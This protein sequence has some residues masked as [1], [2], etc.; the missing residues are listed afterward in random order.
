MRETLTHYNFPAPTPQQVRQTIGLTLEESIHRLTEGRC[1]EPLTSEMVKH[2]RILHTTKAASH[3]PLRRSHP[4][5]RRT[6]SSQHLHHPRKQQRPSRPAPT[7][8]PTRN[9]RL[10]R[11]HPKRRRHTPPQTRRLPLHRPHSAPASP[12]P[13][14]T[15]PRSRRH[16][17]RHSLR[18]ERQPTLLLGSLRLRRRPTLQS[19][20]TRLRTPI[21][22]RPTHAY[23]PLSTELHHLASLF[24][25]F[26][27]R[28]KLCRQFLRLISAASSRSSAPAALLS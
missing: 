19:P 16:R 22:H 3:A 1:E 18:P 24:S 8:R 5:P 21:T 6:P 27:L 4:N 2:Y 12:H 9:H 28:S 20:R 7:H 10:Y 15:N 23:Y 26:R 25:R 17:N 14:L 11:H 13:R